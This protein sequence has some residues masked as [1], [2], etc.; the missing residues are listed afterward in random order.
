MKG[1]MTTLPKIK[2]K[3]GTAEPQGVTVNK[4][5]CYHPITTVNDPTQNISRPICRRY[6]DGKCDKHNR[7]CPF[8]HPPDR[9]DA[10]V[11]VAYNRAPGHCY[12]GKKL[13]RVLNSK[14][15]IENEPNLY[16]TVCSRT[17]KSNKLC[18]YDMI[19][20][21]LAQTS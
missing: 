14:A 11:K 17:R 16:I 8:Y 13:K 18:Y 21:I 2:T 12:C 1:K 5:P 15:C 9:S 4:R 6:V 7:Y 19:N 10:R 20:R 3:R